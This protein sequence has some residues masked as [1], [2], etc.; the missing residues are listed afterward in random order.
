MSEQDTIIVGLDIGTMGV[1]VVVGE[2]TGDNVDIIGVGSALSRGVRSGV[3]AD[4]AACAASIRQ[5]VREAQNMAGY[6]ITEVFVSIAGGHIVGFNS[7]GVVAVNGAQVSDADLTRVIDAATTVAVPANRQV[8]HVLPQEYVIDGRRG[9]TQPLRMTAVRMETRV[10]IVT[11]G[12]GAVE[13]IVNCCELA[14]LDV[15]SLVLESLASSQAVVTDDEKG[16]GVCLV[17][18]GGGTA[19]IAVFC[20]R[21]IVHTAV[22]PVG[23]DLVT[24]DIA[25]GLRTPYDEAEKI[26]RRYGT[27]AVESVD[28]EDLMDVPSVGGR[29]PRKL[30]RKVLG[31]II[32][33]RLVEMLQFVG[34]EI[35]RTGYE[36]HLGAGVV[37]TGGTALLPEIERLAQEV[38]DLPVRVGRPGDKGIGGL[39]E[40]IRSPARSTGL[41]LVLHGAAELGLGGPAAGCS[42]PFPEPPGSGR[43]GPWAWLGRRLRQVW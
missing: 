22:L 35:R 2:V 17:D 10:H 33:P 38:L 26:K 25:R 34:E 19:G 15:T 12:Q 11:A 39:V 31:E 6:E 9:I 23:G 27:A 16:L 28:W 36:D 29:K 14:E 37:L 3:I 7:Q 4:M 40:L 43:T 1:R 13:D 41:G 21:A 42:E 24:K 20:E 30:S 32:E 5:A 18:I 8:L